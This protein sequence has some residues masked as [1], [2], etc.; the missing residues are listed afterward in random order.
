MG[1]INR[2]DEIEVIETNSNGDI[3]DDEDDKHEGSLKKVD[4]TKNINYD[5]M[6]YSI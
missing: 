1:Y 4:D 2:D 5:G 3:D 6:R